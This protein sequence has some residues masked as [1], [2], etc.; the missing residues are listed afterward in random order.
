MSE[1]ISNVYN[2]YLK[3]NDHKKQEKMM[4]CFSDICKP[5]AIYV[6]RFKR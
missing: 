6:L 3:K 1:A 4:K 2:L 5:L